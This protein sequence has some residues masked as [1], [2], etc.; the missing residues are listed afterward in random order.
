[1]TN[2][3]RVSFDLRNLVFIV[4]AV[5]NQRLFKLKDT[6]VYSVKDIEFRNLNFGTSLKLL[7]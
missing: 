7:T 2:E 3:N 5:T 4:F 6:S 1:M